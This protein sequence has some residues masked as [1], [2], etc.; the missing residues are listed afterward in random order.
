MSGMLS[1]VRLRSLEKDEAKR[2]F[3]A[4]ATYV[5]QDG[6]EVLRSTFSGF[7]ANRTFWRAEDNKGEFVSHAN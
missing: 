5:N 2:L 7:P 4:H 3:S 6:V 1:P